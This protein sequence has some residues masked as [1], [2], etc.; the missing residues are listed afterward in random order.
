M[1]RGVGLALF[2]AGITIRLFVGSF[3]L[4][5]AFMG[6]MML[7]GREV[8]GRFETHQKIRYRRRKFLKERLH[9]ALCGAEAKELEP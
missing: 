1:E 8:L 7:G 2:V 9:G 5:T 6:L 4:H 3:G